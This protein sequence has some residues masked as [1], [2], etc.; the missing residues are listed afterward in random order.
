MINKNKV[1]IKRIEE[2]DLPKIVAFFKRTVLQ[3]DRVLS[4]LVGKTILLKPNLLGAFAPEKAVTTNPVII[5]AVIQILQEI[6]CKILVGDSP[7]GSISYEHALKVCGIQAVADKYNVEIVNISKYKISKTTHKQ[8]DITY[9]HIYDEVD[10]IINLAKYKTHGLM[11]FTGA[12]KNLYGLVPGLKKADYH[13]TYPNSHNFAEFLSSLYAVLK[14]KLLFSVIDGIV[15]MEGKGPSGGKPRN[16][17]YLFASECASSADYVA[18]YM[19]GFKPLSID[20]IRMTMEIDGVLPSRIASNFLWQENIIPN[21]DTGIV[22]LRTKLLTIMPNQVSKLVK[23]VLWYRPVITDKCKKCNICFESCP[24][25]AIKKDENGTL[26][27]DD[28]ICIRCLCC[29]EF[30]PHQAIEIKKSFVAN[31]LIPT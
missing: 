5:E 12:V 13:R 18:A 30:C 9:S 27:I 2:Y 21:V 23:S 24:V 7:G 17:G 3:K 26:K 20:L 6:D 29:H 28:K 14:P 11:Q 22:K 25:E 8:H 1:L 15:G 10:Y 19:M 16:F 4:N 31:I